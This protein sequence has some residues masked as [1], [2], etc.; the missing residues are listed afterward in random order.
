MS[1]GR[2]EDKRLARTKGLH[3]R[4]A[5]KSTSLI[6]ALIKYSNTSYSVEVNCKNDLRIDTAVQEMRTRQD[7]KWYI[8]SEATRNK[9]YRVLVADP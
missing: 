7:T 8:E 1:L 4:G 9:K 6:R 3:Y 2:A 5:R